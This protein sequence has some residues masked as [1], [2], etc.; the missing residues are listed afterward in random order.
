MLG[1]YDSNFN[2]IAQ[3]EAYDPATGLWSTLAP[4]PAA[5]L[6]SVAV[7]GADGRIY[8]LGGYDSGFTVTPTVQA[9]D[10]TKGT[11][12]LAPDMIWPRIEF[13]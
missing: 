5:R 2:V 13:A 8:V 3:A 4:M 6:Y 7:T 11:W 9:Y 12:E 1:G 10:P